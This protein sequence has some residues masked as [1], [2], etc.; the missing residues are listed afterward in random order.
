MYYLFKTPW[1]LKAL[2]PKRT[3][4]KS[5]KEKVLYLSFDDGPH[6]SMTA[7]VLDELKA[8]GAKASFFCIGKNIESYP[9]MYKRIQEEGHGVG[10]HS[11]SH[12][13]GFKTTDELYVADVMKAAQLVPSKLFRPPYGRLKSSQARKLAALEIVMWDVLSG[14]FDGNLDKKTCLSKLIR[15]TRPGS[16]ITFHDSEKAK[17]RLEYVLPRFLSHYHKLGYSFQKL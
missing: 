7:F 5:R 9:E 8:Y 11:Y 13:N 3:W 4:N 2:Y 17:E 12:L 1:W 16:I 15:K 14:D 10:N 6:P